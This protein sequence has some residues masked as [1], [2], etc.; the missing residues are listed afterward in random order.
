MS[1]Q[2][3]SYTERRHSRKRT[4][5]LTVHWLCVSAII[6]EFNM[7]CYGCALTGC[8]S[9]PHVR[10]TAA[11]VKFSDDCAHC[12]ASGRPALAV[13][14]VVNKTQ[15][16]REYDTKV[17]LLR[18]ITYINEQPTRVGV[19]QDVHTRVHD[20]LPTSSTNA[21]IQYKRKHSRHSQTRVQVH[22]LASL[23]HAL[24]NKIQSPG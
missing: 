24:S 17:G 18:T 19:P 11:H 12:V 14:H 4:L 20:T 8:A 10:L 23:H 9:A 5:K 13:S 16:R 21:H 1:K 15:E 2:I 7:G 3:N 6:A 22:R